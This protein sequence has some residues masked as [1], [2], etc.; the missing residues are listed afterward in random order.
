MT[1]GTASVGISVARRFCR[2]SSIT[3]KTRMIASTSVRST[4]SIEISTKGVVS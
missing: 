2:N 1:T 3:R 4:S